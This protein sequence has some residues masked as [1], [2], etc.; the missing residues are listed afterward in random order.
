[1]NKLFYAF[2]LAF[3]AIMC[4]MLGG[5]VPAGANSDGKKSEDASYPV[6]LTNQSGSCLE[7][8]DLSK[9][10]LDE[11]S[12]LW[13]CKMP[14]YNIAGTKLR[15]SEKHGKVALA[16]CGGS[17]GCM[18]SYPK[19]ELLWS[20]NAAANNPHSI[21]LMPNG[22]I[23]I[24]SSYG[25][26]V[27]FF[28]TDQ[29]ISETP[30]ASITLED[31]HGVLWD[32]E[33]EVLWAI[34]RNVL[35]AYHVERTADGGVSVTKEDDLCLTIPSDHA[36][37]LA[38]VYG[39]RNELWVTTTSHVYRF[40][41]AEKTFSTDYKGSSFLDRS[42]IKGVGNFDD[43]SIVFI[44]PDGKFKSW[45]GQSAFLL[46]ASDGTKVESLNSADKHFYKIRVW[47]ARYQ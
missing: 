38:P 14:Y 19:G 16:V 43:G 27:R 8:H 31:A 47:D 22:V 2:K 29:E 39:N 17:Y 41:K 33:K 21:E 20:T 10:K 44:Y 11:H 25:D 36:H 30:S 42:G 23:A 35:A 24:A 1:M 37:D 45:T 15:C 13:S 12:L 18:I 3:S 46:S 26:E 28:T 9:G 5:A 7:V 34:G 4:G 32:E 40:N 6:A